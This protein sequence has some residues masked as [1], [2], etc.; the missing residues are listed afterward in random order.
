MNPLPLIPPVPERAP[1]LPKVRRT[2]KPTRLHG[3]REVTHTAY[4]LTAI[5]CL[6][7]K[8]PSDAYGLSRNRRVRVVMHPPKVLVQVADR[9]PVKV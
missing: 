1:P 3:K 4:T 6:F 2:F 5:P 8:S 7:G 9:V